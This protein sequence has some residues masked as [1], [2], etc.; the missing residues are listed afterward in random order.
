MDHWGLV[1][2]KMAS[3]AFRWLLQYI[4][5]RR[6]ERN[7]DI[8]DGIF[9]E[10]KLLIMSLENQREDFWEKSDIEISIL[11]DWHDNGSPLQT[12]T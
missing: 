9:P 11:T 7:I 5:I 3:C 10:K 6:K 2:L 1:D 8:N 4:F 12:R